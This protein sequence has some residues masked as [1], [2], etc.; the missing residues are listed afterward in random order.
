MQLNEFKTNVGHI[1]VIVS[2]FKSVFTM[3]IKKSLAL[4]R[5]VC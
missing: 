4:I 2:C 1:I 5:F 3:E